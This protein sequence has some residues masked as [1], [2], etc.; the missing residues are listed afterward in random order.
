MAEKR[1]MIFAPEI[2]PASF[3]LLCWKGEDRNS[4]SVRDF[5]DPTVQANP[6]YAK[7]FPFTIAHLLNLKLVFEAPYHSTKDRGFWDQLTQEFNQKHL[8]A[9]PSASARRQAAGGAVEKEN[10]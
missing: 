10:L 9:R 7:E 4:W 5:S 6:R 1:R 8:A 2:N 3:V